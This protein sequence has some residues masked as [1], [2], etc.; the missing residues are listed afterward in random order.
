LCARGALSI[1]LLSLN[2]RATA[3]ACSSTLAACALIVGCNSYLAYAAAGQGS[4]LRASA[5]AA[6]CLAS[7][8]DAALAVSSALASEVAASVGGLP[9]LVCD[10][11]A[12][13]FP[14]RSGG[15]GGEAAAPCGGLAAGFPAFVLC[16]TGQPTAGT[17]AA[18]A[19]LAAARTATNASVAALT[20]LASSCDQRIVTRF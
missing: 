2:L 19:L 11:G 6:A 1:P 7:A 5:S 14:Q 9:Q 8:V 15:G 13:S 3:A 20:A 12:L 10:P 18:Q 4:S 16:Q 17:P